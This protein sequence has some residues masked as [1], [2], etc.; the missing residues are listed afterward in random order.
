[1][2]R[3]GMS[4]LEAE[5]RAVLAEGIRNGGLSTTPAPTVTMPDPVTMDFNLKAL[6]T[7]EGISFTATLAGAVHFVTIVGVCTL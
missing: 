2:T 5:L 6:R 3:P 1:M 4:I 7:V